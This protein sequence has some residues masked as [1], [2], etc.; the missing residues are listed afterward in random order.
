MKTLSLKAISSE[1]SKYLVIG[2]VGYV[3]DLG[4]FNVF[5]HLL[6]SNASYEPLLAK[7]ASSGLA[8]VFTFFGNKYWTFRSHQSDRHYAAEIALF[9]LVNVLGMAINIATLWFSHYVL[10]FTSL[11][12]DNISGNLI[13]VALATAFRF[14]GTRLF[15]FRNPSKETH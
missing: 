3:I 11:L 10:G 13:G 14:I 7:F 2:A 12:A 9:I 8:I 6:N 5:F 15:V 1:A 4:L